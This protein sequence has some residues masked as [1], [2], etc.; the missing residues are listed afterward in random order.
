MV[1]PRPATEKRARAAIG[2]PDLVR[3]AQN[4]IGAPRSGYASAPTR[5]PMGEDFLEWESPRFNANAIK[6]TQIAP[7][8]RR[9][10]A[11]DGG[12]R[13]GSDHG[14]A[15]AA[16]VKKQEE[17]GAARQPDCARRPKRRR[18]AQIRRYHLAPPCILEHA[19]GTL[20]AP[21]AKR[22]SARAAR[23]ARIGIY[24]G[25]EGVRAG[26]LP[27]LLPTKRVNPPRG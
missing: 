8:N 10:C 20:S 5:M 4:G 2:A 13:G 17:R 7:P 6:P 1:N 18:P 9:R 15:G 23:P 3:G 11:P 19:S 22:D 24:Y 16:I 27:R 26:N 12:F 21:P 14:S 25:G